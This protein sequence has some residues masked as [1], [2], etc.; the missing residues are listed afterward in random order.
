MLNPEL[1]IAVTGGALMSLRQRKAE[2]LSKN[3]NLCVVSE[4]YNIKCA[5]HYRTE[6][7]TMRQNPNRYFCNHRGNILCIKE[8]IE[9]CIRFEAVN[10]LTAINK[11]E[12]N[13]YTV[14][15][16]YTDIYIYTD[17][18]SSIHEESPTSRPYIYDN[19]MLARQSDSIHTHSKTLTRRPHIYGNQMLARQSE[20]IRIH[21]KHW[22]NE[23]E[24]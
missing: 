6:P 14:N 18:Q 11:P 16:M 13:N 19:Q 21:S 22:R 10:V 1:G 15:Q 5:N 17:P 3:K 24:L 9:A 8:S 20:S 23:I 7:R 12:L 2:R 4:D